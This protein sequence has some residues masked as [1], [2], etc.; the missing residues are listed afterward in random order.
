MK[1][2]ILMAAALIMAA[3]CNQIQTLEEENPNGNDGKVAVTVNIN[4]G[5]ETRATG[6]SDDKEKNVSDIQLFVFDST[7]NIESYAKGS[8]SSFTVNITTGYKHFIAL[9]NCPD[10]GSAID[11]RNTM[12]ATISK[13]SDNATDKLQMVGEA[14]LSEVTLNSKPKVDIAVKRLVTKVAIK[15]VTVNFASPY[16]AAKEFKIKGVYLI[17]VVANNNYAMKLDESKYEW[18]NKL[19]V[20]LTNPAKDL[21]Q[22]TGLDVTVANG[23]SYS[24]EHTFYCYPNKYTGNYTSASWC[25]RKTRLVVETTLG[26]ATGY[27]SLEL[28]ILERNKVYTI[29]ELTITK[30]GSQNPYEQISTADATFSITVSDWEEGE[31]KSV[32]I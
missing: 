13:L 11:S 5:A 15:K 22:D 23:S 9:A 20:D 2:R 18:V 10:L 8:Q 31:S 32:T 17:N 3:A 12:E 24:T 7:G 19:Q 30:R 16:L 25:E 1:T 4:G 27:Y 21:T 28:P 26:G 14:Y 29:T 6:A